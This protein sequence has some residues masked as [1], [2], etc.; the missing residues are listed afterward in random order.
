[1]QTIG[2]RGPIIPHITNKETIVL[3]GD[4]AGNCSVQLDSMKSIVVRDSHCG[5]HF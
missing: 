3:P 5:A 2:F 4:R 1:L